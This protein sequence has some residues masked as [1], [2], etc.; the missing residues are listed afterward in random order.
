MQG[1][2][3]KDSR[4]PKRARRMYIQY[5]CKKVFSGG[6]TIGWPW[7]ESGGGVRSWGLGRGSEMRV[8]QMNEI[9]ER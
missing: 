5:F 7:G 3:R 8:V 6:G 2:R 9:G 4:R 1:G